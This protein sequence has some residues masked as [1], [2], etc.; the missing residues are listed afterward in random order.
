MEQIDIISDKSNQIIDMLDYIDDRILVI[1]RKNARKKWW[2][3]C[4]QEF[5]SIK[6]G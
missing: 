5:N 3:M 4:S 6:I 2:T 1:L